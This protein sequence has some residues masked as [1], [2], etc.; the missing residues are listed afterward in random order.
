MSKLQTVSKCRAAFS[1]E[2]LLRCIS[3]KA[4]ACSLV[5]VGINWDVI[6]CRKVGSSEFQPNLIRVATARNRSRSAG[7]VD[8]LLYRPVANPPNRMRRETRSGLRTAYAIE[9]AQ[10]CENPK[11]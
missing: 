8:A 3:L 5:A 2:R 1:A 6:I 9:I 4:W 7:V 11:I 10:P